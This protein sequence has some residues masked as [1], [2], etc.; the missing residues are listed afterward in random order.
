[1]DSKDLD[2]LL[3][4]REGT[5]FGGLVVYPN[6]PPGTVLDAVSEKIVLDCG[7]SREGDNLAQFIVAAFL[8]VPALVALARAVHFDRKRAD[9]ERALRI[10]AEHELAEALCDRDQAVT[11]ADQA[12]KQVA[13]ERECRLQNEGEC[14]RIDAEVG[15][16]REEVASLQRIRDQSV[17]GHESAY[18]TIQEIAH[19]VRDSGAPF[20]PT[21][22]DRVRGLI[23][24][25]NAA[26]A[27]VRNQ[28]ELE[29][30]Y[31]SA[32]AALKAVDAE[33]SPIRLGAVRRREEVVRELVEYRVRETAAS[34]PVAVQTVPTTLQEGE[35]YSRRVG[36]GDGG[37]H[38]VE[39][40]G[41]GVREEARL[42]NA[43]DQKVVIEALRG[44]YEAGANALRV[45]LRDLLEVSK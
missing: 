7:S 31:E 12:Q 4:L 40:K 32:M 3:K 21:L 20:G 27:S 29:G 5:G 18:A 23:G 15:R 38:L 16:L 28:T 19:A 1:M 9:Q 37:C 2:M 24:Q 8:H 33:L 34:G 44:A 6:M 10:K 17:A 36:F 30:K 13:V 39:F 45:R 43:Y 22:V 41:P 14:R 25:R 11:R 35:Y 26:Q 42:W